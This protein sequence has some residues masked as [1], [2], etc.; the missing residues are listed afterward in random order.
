MKISDQAEITDIIAK[1]QQVLV[2]S[3]PPWLAKIMGLTQT[4]ILM[5][6]EEEVI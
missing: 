2:A 6:T 4:N 1:L 3:P 5:E